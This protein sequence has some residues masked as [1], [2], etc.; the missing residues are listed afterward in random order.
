MKPGDIIVDHNDKKWVVYE[1][2]HS[3][4]YT[5]HLLIYTLDFETQKNQK[6]ILEQEIKEVVPKPL[7]VEFMMFSWRE[8]ELSDIKEYL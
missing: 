7:N 1:I 3:T 2:D 5:K 6:I 4:Y 8:K